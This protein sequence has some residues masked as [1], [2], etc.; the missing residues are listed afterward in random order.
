MSITVTSAAPMGKDTVSVSGV[1]RPIGRQVS[2]ILTR[3]AL[4]LP[5]PMA[6]DRRTGIVLIDFASAT[7]SGIEPE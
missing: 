2:M 6:I 4:G 7:T 3:P 5:S 1:V